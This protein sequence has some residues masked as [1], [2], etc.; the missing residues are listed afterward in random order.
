MDLDLDGAARLLGVHYQTAYRWVRS[1]ALPAMKV[2]GEYRLR[3]EDVRRLA[4]RRRAPKPPPSIGR[5]RDWRPLVA[6]LHTAALEGDEF[7]A[8]RLFERLRV[9][10]VPSLLLCQ[11]LITPVLYRIGE[12]W[13]SGQVSSAQVRVAAGISERLVAML[14]TAS[15]GRPRGLAVVASPSGEGHRLP[16]LMATV[17]LRADCWRVHHFG[18]DVPAD[19]LIEFAL[20]RGASLVVLSPTLAELVDD[21]RRLQDDFLHL[22]GLATLVGR[23]GAPLTELVAQARMAPVAVR[24]SALRELIDLSELEP[25]PEV[26]S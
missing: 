15:R 21:A 25:I 14:A 5:V 13:G 18:A 19:D 4:E 3:E 24:S 8:R 23:P 1:G 16:S 2:A 7:S 17:V 6:Q 20:K 11:E 26:A 22:Y 12:G 10:G 9:A